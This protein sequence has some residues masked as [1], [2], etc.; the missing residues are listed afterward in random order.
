MLPWEYSALELGDG[1]EIKMQQGAWEVNK[2]L[3]SISWLKVLEDHSLGR[4][5]V[6]APSLG[7]WP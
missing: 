6:E 5:W 2:E 3:F 7:K 1:E 4:G